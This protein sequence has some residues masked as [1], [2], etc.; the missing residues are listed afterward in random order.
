MIWNPRETSPRESRTTKPEASFPSDSL[1]K[2]M[3]VDSMT[4]ANTSD[5]MWSM[6]WMPIGMRR[7]LSHVSLSFVRMNS[8]MLGIASWPSAV[9]YRVAIVRVALP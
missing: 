1:M 5:V 3:H 8:W 6:R 4:S 2:L 9:M 7:S